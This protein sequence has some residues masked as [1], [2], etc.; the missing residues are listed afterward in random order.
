MNTCQHSTE[1]RTGFTKAWKFTV[2]M[3]IVIWNASDWKTPYNYNAISL[4]NCWKDISQYKTIYKKGDN[5]HCFKNKYTSLRVSRRFPLFCIRQYL[6]YKTHS[7]FQS[8]WIFLTEIGAKVAYP[9]YYAFPVIKNTD[10]TLA[11]HGY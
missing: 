7:R 8:E 9:F 10:V 3:S 4:L 11:P 5:V 1:S 6:T 2:L